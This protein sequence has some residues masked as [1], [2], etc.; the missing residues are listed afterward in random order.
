M[1]HPEVTGDHRADNALIT[2]ATN[3]VGIEAGCALAGDIPS[4]KLGDALAAVLERWNA[5]ETTLHQMAVVL[6]QARG[7]S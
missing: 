3:P 4:E 2:T 6:F 5:F 7:K 1:S